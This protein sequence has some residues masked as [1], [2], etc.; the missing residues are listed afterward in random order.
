MPWDPSAK[1]QVVEKTGNMVAATFLH[2]V[3]RNNEPQLHVHA[4]IANATKASDGK[5]NTV[6]NDQLYRNRHLLGQ[7]EVATLLNEYDVQDS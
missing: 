7:D 1:M 6:H 2:D 3:N 4:V 5:W